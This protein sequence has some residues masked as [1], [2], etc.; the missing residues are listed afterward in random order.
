MKALLDF[1]GVSSLENVEAAYEAAYRRTPTRGGSPEAPAAWLRQGERLARDVATRPFN[2]GAL[3]AT[4]NEVRVLTRLR[5]DVSE[6]RL[7]RQLAECGV[8]LVLVP[9]LPGSG[10]HG[11]TRWLGPDKALVQMSLRYP[12]DDVFWFTLYHE[13]GHVLLHRRR[14]VFIKA[15]DALDDERENEANVFASDTLIPPDQF[16]RFLA[17]DRWQSAEGVRRFAD[18][19]EIAPSIVVGRLQH[20]RRVPYS[21]LNHL[22]SRFRWRTNPGNGG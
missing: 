4:L 11:A 12:W 21:H 14:E 19:I 8:A 6:R 18:T 13:L 7:K 20:E 1:F 16:V 22:R 10:A 3:R 15:D 9:H 17:G 2:E 5:P